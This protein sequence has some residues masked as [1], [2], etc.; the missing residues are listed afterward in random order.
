MFLFGS[1]QF[2]AS[3]TVI[4]Y[5]RDTGNKWFAGRRRLK[6][7]DLFTNYRANITTETAFVLINGAGVL[8]CR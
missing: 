3:E 6:V 5:T 4:D 1:F 7:V 2:H 8:Y